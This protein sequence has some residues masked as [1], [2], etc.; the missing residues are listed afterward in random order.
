MSSSELDYKIPPAPTYRTPPALVTLV[1]TVLILAFVTFSI[2]YFC[3]HY[4]QGLFHNWALQRTASGSVVRVSP[5]RSPPRGLDNTLLDKFPTFVYSSVKDLREE[6]S[7]SLECAICLMEFEDDSMLRHLTICCHV[8]HQECIDLWLESHKTCPVCRTDLDL[9]P[10]QTSKQGDNDNENNNDNNNVD[11]DE[12]MVQFPC[13]A[14]RIDVR[15]EERNNVGEITGGQ[16][17]ATN[18]HD[19]ENMSMPRGEEPRFSKSHSTGHSIV[20]IRG[21]EKD[22]AKYTLRLPE[23]VIRGGHNTSKSCTNY[24]EMTL[25][26][27]TPCSNCGF[28]KPLTGS[29][30]LAH[31][32]DH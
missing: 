20:M 14:I 16:I 15:E 19:C 29:S 23:H 6:K 32:Q 1:L 25:T 5:E 22:N 24:N 21:E 8:F 27:P 17:N 18:Q 2:V 26:E 3:K 28:V 30:S 13:D 10:N 11:A 12:A 4:F 9:N 31:S 7:Y